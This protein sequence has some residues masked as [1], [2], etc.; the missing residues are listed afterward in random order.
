MKDEVNKKMAECIC[1]KQ[2]TSHNQSE[3]CS[4]KCQHEYYANDEGQIE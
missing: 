2:F 4:G 1:G 3:F